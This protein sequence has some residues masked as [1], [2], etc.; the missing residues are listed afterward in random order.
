VPI[1]NAEQP[2]ALGRRLAGQ[3]LPH[4]LDREPDAARRARATARSS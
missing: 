2:P 4:L 3:Q 1:E